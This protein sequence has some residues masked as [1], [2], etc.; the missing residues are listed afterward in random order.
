MDPL[1]IKATEY[2]PEIHLDQK[3]NLFEFKGN[4]LPENAVNFFEPVLAW[5][6]D[7]THKANDKTEIIFNL[8]YINSSS[9]KKIMDI[10]EVLEEITEKYQ[11]EV[12]IFWRYE[13]DDEVNEDTGKAFQEITTLPFKLEVY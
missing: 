12:F 10:L 6:E 5:L 8:G 2:T 3:N 1:I 13:E 7:Y 11:K 9:S 4:S